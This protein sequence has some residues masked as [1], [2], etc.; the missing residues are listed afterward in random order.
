MILAAIAEANDC[1]IVTENERDFTG[2]R[3]V[4]LCGRTDRDGATPP[5]ECRSYCACCNKPA[6]VILQAGLTAHRAG[7]S[8]RSMP[9][10][11]PGVPGVR[12]LN[13]PLVNISTLHLHLRQIVVG[14]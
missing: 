2:L 12:V 3:F 8:H 10:H 9:G 14:L 7:A 1:V 5:R 4:I 11:V 13:A 6:P